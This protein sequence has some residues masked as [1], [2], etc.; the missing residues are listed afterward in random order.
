MKVLRVNFHLS[1]PMGF[2]KL[3]GGTTLKWVSSMEPKKYY[4]PASTDPMKLFN[5]TGAEVFATKLYEHAQKYV[6]TGII[7]RILDYPSLAE[8][9]LTRL[10]DAIDAM[11][12]LDGT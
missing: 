5:V 4:P 3:N 1:H 11:V 10:E 8:K 2:G 9:P 7:T 12:M 6:R